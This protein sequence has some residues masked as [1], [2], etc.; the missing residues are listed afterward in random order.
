VSKLKVTMR[1][2]G[3]VTRLLLAGPI[4][5]EARS[6]LMPAAEAVGKSCV[7]DMQGVTHLN[8]VG[9]RD[10]ALFLKVLRLGRTVAYDRCTDEV[11]RTMGM[12]TSFRSGLPVR[13][14]YRAY[15][16]DHCGHEQMELYVEGKD[17]AAG[18]LPP[19]RAAA[20]ASCGRE[21][22]AFVPDQEFFQFLV[23]A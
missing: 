9:I 15:G 13:S 18:T 11:V 19:A 4:D 22:E 20:C 2:E 23:G 5:E 1:Q 7:L 14:F 10:W 12:V 21:T 16:C 17:Y 6:V 8:S 3:A